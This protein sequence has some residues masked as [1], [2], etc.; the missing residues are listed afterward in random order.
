VLDGWETEE[1][2]TTGALS[3]MPKPPNGKIAAQEIMRHACPRHSGQVHLKRHSTTVF[4]QDQQE[5][6]FDNVVGYNE[7]SLHGA[8][9][10]PSSQDWRQ[11][12]PGKPPRYKPG[13]YDP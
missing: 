4:R 1:E 7:F 9:V 6:A 12:A 5:N 11:Y 10:Q 2:E 3:S 8:V 13:H